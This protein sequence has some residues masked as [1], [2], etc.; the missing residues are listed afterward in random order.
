[1]YFVCQEL[2]NTIYVV[3]K[4]DVITGGFE[5]SLEDR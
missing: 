3:V 5:K 1:M 2:S 4:S